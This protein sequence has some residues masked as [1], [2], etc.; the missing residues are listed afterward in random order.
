M[1]IKCN[2]CGRRS[3]KYVGYTAEERKLVK[4]NGYV[5]CESCG[6]NFMKYYKMLLL[7]DAIISPLD[8]KI[9]E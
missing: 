5:L 7:K 1:K 9:K 6:R 3:E 8:G 4:D 2:K